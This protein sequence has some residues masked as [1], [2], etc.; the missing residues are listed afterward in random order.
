MQNTLAEWLST[1]RREPIF[2]D[3]NVQLKKGKR[4][5]SMKTMLRGRIE[6]FIDR[7]EF[8]DTH[9]PGSATNPLIFPLDSIEAEGVLKWNF[10]EFYQNMNVYRVVF[11]DPKASG[12]KYADAIGLL[13]ELS[14]SHLPG[15]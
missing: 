8:R 15:R 6:L 11:G 13:H 12:R 2:S 4:I 5:D 14:R 3:E 9:K 10:F 1:G 7:L